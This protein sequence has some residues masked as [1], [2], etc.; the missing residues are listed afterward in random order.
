MEIIARSWEIGWKSHHSID[1]LFM[2]V[3]YIPNEYNKNT[4]LKLTIICHSG[5]VPNAFIKWT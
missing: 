5:F 3:S 2:Y 4:Y 1:V